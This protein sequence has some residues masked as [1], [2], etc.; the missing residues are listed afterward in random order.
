MTNPTTPGVAE[1]LDA[2]PFCGRE[3]GDDLIDVLYPSG[4]R[5][6]D[7]SDEGGVRFY[8]TSGKGQ[9]WQIV[10]APSAGG[11]GAEMHAD[12]REEVVAKWN[13]RAIAQRGGKGDA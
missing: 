7:S 2:C 1:L 8:G 9:C 11:C 3:L 10:C 4:T 5:W 6:S 13:R 12:S